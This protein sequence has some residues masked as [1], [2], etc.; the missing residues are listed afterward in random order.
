[1]Y[2]TYLRLNLHV[3]DSDMEVLRRARKKIAEHHR[4]GQAR[5][6][7]RWAFYREMLEHHGASQD[8]LNRITFARL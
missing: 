2:S 5:K 8:L 3:N 1:M 4:L 6:S 7:D